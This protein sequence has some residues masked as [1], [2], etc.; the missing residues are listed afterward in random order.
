M[1]AEPCAVVT[2]RQ[3]RRSILRDPEGNETMKRPQPIGGI[4][5]WSSVLAPTSNAPISRFMD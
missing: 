1:R 2:L 3:D 5:H 4:G